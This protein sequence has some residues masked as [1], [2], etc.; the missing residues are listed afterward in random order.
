M[1]E[2]EEEE[3]WSLIIWSIGLLYPNLSSSPAMWIKLASLD[4]PEEDLPANYVC[5]RNMYFIINCSWHT[6]ALPGRENSVQLST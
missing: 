3:A 4:F 2:K 5:M 1:L 6:A